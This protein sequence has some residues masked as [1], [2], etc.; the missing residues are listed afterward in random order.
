MKCRRVSYRRD[1][2]KDEE[3]V[4]AVAGDIVGSPRMNRY[5]IRGRSCGNTGETVLVGGWLL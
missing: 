4:L 2:R 3:V 5:D 1:I